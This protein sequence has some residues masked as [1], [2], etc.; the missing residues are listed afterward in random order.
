ME[1]IPHH[2]FKDIG[3]NDQEKSRSTQRAAYFC[4]PIQY[5][6]RPGS[7]NHQPTCILVNI[8]H[9]VIPSLIASWCRS[10]AALP[11]YFSATAQTVA[12]KTL[13]SFGTSFGSKRPQRGSMEIDRF[14]LLVYG[15]P[16]RA[17][18]STAVAASASE[19]LN[20]KT[21]DTH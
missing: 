11:E 19:W 3:A 9:F 18:G 2:H 14:G 17:I 1:K 16:R 15:P 5:L 7:R 12:L 20:R 10:L 21:C 13:S 4:H 6:D 8:C